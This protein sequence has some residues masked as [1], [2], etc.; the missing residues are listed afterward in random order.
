M[1]RALKAMD[2]D[3]DL[4]EEAEAPPEEDEEDEMPDEPTPEPPDW[5]DF[6][7]DEDVVDLRAW[8]PLGGV[9]H[10]NLLHLPPQPKQAK[11]WIM[12]QGDFSYLKSE[13]FTWG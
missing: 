12:T 8:S 2:E 6:D 10:F 11:G 7:Q 3:G 9:I 1:L 5:E 13:K 4:E